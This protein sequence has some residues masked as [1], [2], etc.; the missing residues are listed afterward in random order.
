MMNHLTCKL[1]WMGVLLV[2]VVAFSTTTAVSEER[3]VLRVCADPN[4][5]PLSH[6]DRTGY[7]NRVAELLGQTLGIPVEYTWFPQRRGFVRNTLRAKDPNSGREKCDLIMGVPESFELAITTKPY[8][9][10][11]YALVFRKGENLDDIKTGNDFLVLDEARKSALRVGIFDQT[12]AAV[13]LTRAGFHKQIIAYPTLNADPS[14]YPGQL[15]ERELRSGAIDA[16]ILWGPIAGYFVKQSTDVELTIIPLQSM[17]GVRFDFPISMA[18]RFGEGAWKTQLEDFIDRHIDDIE[19]ILRDFNVPL[20]AED[21][22][23]K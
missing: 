15:I 22:R 4:S 6:H 11:T 20:L 13:W 21:G 19:T 12:P 1:N 17:P 16:A 5:M 9:R 18:V 23:F 14:Q 2:A 8:Y 10:S 7:E 3:K